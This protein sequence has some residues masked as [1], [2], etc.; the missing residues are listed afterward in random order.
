MDLHRHSD[1]NVDVVSLIKKLL[2]EQI[3]CPGSTPFK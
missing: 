1:A 2:E 3:Q